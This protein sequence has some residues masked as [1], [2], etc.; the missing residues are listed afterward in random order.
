MI[1]IRLVTQILNKK[2]DHYLKIE[3]KIL[4]TLVSNGKRKHTRSIQIM[5]IKSR[6]QFCAQVLQVK[7]N[8]DGTQ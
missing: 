5:T 1:L 3:Y 4:S 8:Y 6:T 2:K 7:E